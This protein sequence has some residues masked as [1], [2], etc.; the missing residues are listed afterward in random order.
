MDQTG[1][2][3][4]YSYDAAGRLAGLT[5]GSD[6]PIVSYTYDTAGRL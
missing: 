6:D 2:T 3:V 4:N 5:D 1:Y